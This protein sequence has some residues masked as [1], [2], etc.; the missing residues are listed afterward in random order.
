MWNGKCVQEEND[1]K[2]FKHDFDSFY[3]CEMKNA[4]RLDDG[5]H[6][7]EE[8]ISPSG[9]CYP[10]RDLPKYPYDPYYRP[11]APP[12]RIIMTNS[13]V[14]TLSSKT[15]SKI[16]NDY[17]Y[18]DEFKTFS[19]IG[20]PH[21]SNTSKCCRNNLPSFKRESQCEPKIESGRPQQKEISELYRNRTHFCP[22][23]N[24]EKNRNKRYSITPSWWPS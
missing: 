18:N 4:P 20:I 24:N 1:G 5:R 16:N 19:K 15:S 7:F 17:M 23:P 22:I 8:C 9:K 14:G 3:L 21:K 12:T 10:G 2:H 11:N 6:S 13:C